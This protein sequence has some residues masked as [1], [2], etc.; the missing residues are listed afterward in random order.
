MGISSTTLQ[1]RAF[2]DESV[3]SC[4]L[5]EPQPTCP[6]KISPGD[7]FRL[8]S[9]N[10]ILGTLLFSIPNTTDRKPSE[11]ASRSTHCDIICSG[12][13]DFS[14]RGDAT[15]SCGGADLDGLPRPDTAAG[16]E[17]PRPRAVYPA[18]PG[19]SPAGAKS[20]ELIN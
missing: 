18:T 11:N 4:G 5:F 17:H 6:R 7:A 2:A 3:R 13:H 10:D 9:D 1:A 19:A 8:L 16:D 12:D 14:D 15:A 20:A